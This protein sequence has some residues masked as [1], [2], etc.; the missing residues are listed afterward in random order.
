MEMLFD[1]REPPLPPMRLHAR[2][3]TS[4]ASSL[5]ASIA[6][7]NST[8]SATSSG[9]VSTSTAAPTSQSPLPRPFDTSLGNNFTSPSCPAFFDSFLS[10]TTFQDCLPLSLL[11]QVSSFRPFHSRIAFT[12]NPQTSNS[13]FTASRSL[14]RLTQTLDA[15]CAV[16]LPQ[17]ADLMASY[18]SALQADANC[19]ADLQMQNPMVA[20]A[21]NGF[22]AYPSLYSAGCLKD[23]DGSYCFANAVTN[24]SAPTSS[25]VY[26]L[27]LGVQLPTGTQPACTS[28]LQST[29]EVF[30]SAAGNSSLPL[31]RDYPVAAGQI[32][33]ECGPA[34]VVASV[35]MNSAAM[36]VRAGGWKWVLGVG[37][38]VVMG[39]LG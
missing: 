13:F 36:S 7:S 4:T 1:A 12:N 24:A 39:L 17:C 16:N 11:L 34:F 15:T 18:A 20:Q 38:V 25:Y 9:S 8:A 33:A 19:G 37:M 10:N 5:P 29:M 23:S 26:Y 32:D 14:V 30:A 22:L 2:Q 27:P 35:S 28:C 21:Y 3:D 31:S 6:P